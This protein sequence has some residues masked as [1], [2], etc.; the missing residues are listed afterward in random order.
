MFP[1]GKLAQQ[2]MNENGHKI[3]E[4][5][6]QDEEEVYIASLSRWNEQLKGLVELERGVKI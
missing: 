1:S 6:R 2:A 4:I 3:F 5:F